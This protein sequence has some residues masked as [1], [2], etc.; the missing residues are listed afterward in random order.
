MDWE[1]G[2]C[3]CCGAGHVTVWPCIDPKL[4]KAAPKCKGMKV[5]SL[6]HSDTEALLAYATDRPDAPVL[7][8]ICFVGNR[9][10]ASL[11]SGF[12]HPRI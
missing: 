3:A 9:I 4:I 11:L 12:G 1:E 8:A 7:K 5:C 2:E 10:L 6:C